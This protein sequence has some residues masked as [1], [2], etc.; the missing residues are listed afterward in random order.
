MVAA[1]LESKLKL[2]RALAVVFLVTLPSMIRGAEQMVSRAETPLEI[3]FRL[4]IVVAIGALVLGSWARIQFVWSAAKSLRANPESGALPRWQV[5]Q[6]T[7]A[8]CA[9]WIGLLGMLWRLQGGSLKSASFF[10]VAAFALLLL[11]F[12]RR[13]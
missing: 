5:G 12:P 4:L 8:I 7:G 6:L 2:C 13:P 11:W 1:N 10:Y 3:S 9:Q